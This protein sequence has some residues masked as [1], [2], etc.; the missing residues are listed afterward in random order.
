MLA[1]DRLEYVR[2]LVRER[3][4]PADDVPGRPPQLHE[5]V[6]RLGHEHS[7]EAGAGGDLELVQ[8]LDV[9]HDRALRPVQLERVRVHAPAR[10]PG[11]LERADD[12]VL[13]LD[14]G[15]EV[16]VYLPALDD[17][18]DTRGNRRDLADEVARKVDDVRSE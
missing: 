16:V 7:L 12:A 3:V 14:G 5:R 13:E 2:Q 15:H 8:A 17:G 11:G 4:A 9:E 6:L 10:E 18:A 1:G